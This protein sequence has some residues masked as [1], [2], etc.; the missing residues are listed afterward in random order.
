MYVKDI[1]ILLY[2]KELYVDVKQKKKPKKN[3]LI[4]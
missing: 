4:F 1:L 2:F 3:T